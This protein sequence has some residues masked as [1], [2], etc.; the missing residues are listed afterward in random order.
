MTQF[1][2]ALIHFAA[3][4]KSI[5]E[6]QGLKWMVNTFGSPLFSVGNKR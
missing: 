6:P 1:K 3:R 5:R 2:K 4:F